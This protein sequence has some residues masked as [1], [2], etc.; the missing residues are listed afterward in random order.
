MAPSTTGFMALRLDEV[1]PPK[2]T[3]TLSL[4]SSLS[5]LVANTSGLDSPSSMMGSSCL[6]STPPAAL[7]SL[8]ARI[9]ASLTATSLID[10]VPLRDWMTPTLTLSEAGVVSPVP[11]VSSSL[12]PQAASSRPATARLAMRVFGADRFWADRFWDDRVWAE[13]GIPM[14][15]SVSGRVISADHTET[16]LPV[17]EADVYAG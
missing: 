12:L 4:F 9:S 14:S 16:P 13:R 17:R 8:M 2:T 6:P 7:I 5:T 1:H 10:M 11:A 15:S 3:A